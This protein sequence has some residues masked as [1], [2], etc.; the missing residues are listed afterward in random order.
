[1][2]TMGFGVN[3]LCSAR[4][5]HVCMY[6]NIYV[7]T[8]IC[9]CIFGQARASQAERRIQRSHAKILCRRGETDLYLTVQC[10]IF[11]AGDLKQLNDFKGKPK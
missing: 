3:T 4:C 1:M 8:F 10:Q 9:I 5:T 2:I 7:Y 6:T 11:N